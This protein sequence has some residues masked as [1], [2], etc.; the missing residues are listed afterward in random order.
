MKDW[1]WLAIGGIAL[2]LYSQRTPALPLMQ[3]GPVMSPIR[4][5]VGIQ[6]PVT[7]PF[8]TAYVL[9]PAVPVAPPVINP[10]LQLPAAG[11]QITNCPPV[12]DANGVMIAG[13][14]SIYGPPSMCPT[15]LQAP[16]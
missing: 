16:M 8:N 10:F 4:T 15:G 7:L 6:Q 5:D 3:S 12:Y 13:P 14:V 9:P 11:R 2:Y 1:M